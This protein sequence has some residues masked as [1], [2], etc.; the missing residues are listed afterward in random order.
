MI[1]SVVLSFALFQI[2][3]VTAAFYS[4]DSFLMSAV[5]V[6]LWVGIAIVGATILMH[7]V[8]EQRPKLAT[9]IQVG[10]E[11]VNIA[12]VATVIGIVAG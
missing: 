10:Y 1:L 9:K 6:G 7:N 4:G 5:G 8:V 2:I 12:L 11:I 3:Y